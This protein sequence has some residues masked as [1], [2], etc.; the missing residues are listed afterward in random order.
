MKHGY[1]D[2]FWRKA[3]ELQDQKV[4]SC[5]KCFV[6]NGE[7]RTKPLEKGR[8]SVRRTWAVVRPALRV[9]KW[10]HP[11]NLGLFCTK[12]RRGD[13]VRME[14]FKP[15][16]HMAWFGFPVEDSPPK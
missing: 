3:F 14:K 12:C 10:I 7:E 9:G 6:K 13:R 11:S 8:K 4:K 16:E 5:E 1:T 15:E 2:E